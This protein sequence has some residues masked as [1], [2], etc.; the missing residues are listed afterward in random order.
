M[1]PSSNFQFKLV[2]QRIKV[3]ITR[4]KVSLYWRDYTDK[5]TVTNIF[6][7]CQ[8]KYHQTETVETEIETERESVCVW[9]RR[10]RFLVLFVV[11]DSVKMGFEN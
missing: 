9:E 11:F 4:N 3:W 6:G 7:F 8:R 1:K 10:T 5:R 2:S